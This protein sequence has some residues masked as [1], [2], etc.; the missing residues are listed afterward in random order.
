MPA[1]ERLGPESF[2]RRRLLRDGLWVVD[3]SADWCPFCQAF[4]SE[5]R[6]WDAGPEVRTAIG[7]LTDLDSPLWEA[8][9]IEVTPTVIGFRDGQEFV[10]RDGR[11]GV[12][13]DGSDLEAVRAAVGTER[14]RRDAVRGARP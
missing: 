12:G 1:P 6:T 2:E 7:D 3:F 4:I 13:L 9:D 10:R 14:A 8:L 11:L 5:F